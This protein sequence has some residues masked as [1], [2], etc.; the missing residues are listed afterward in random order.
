MAVFLLVITTFIRWVE[1]ISK[2]G[3]LEHTI[4]KVEDITTKTFEKRINVRRM[5]GIPIIER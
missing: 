5:G 1:R 4:K 2:L 3:R